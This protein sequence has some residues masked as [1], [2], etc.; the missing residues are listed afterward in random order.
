M[1]FIFKVYLNLYFYFFVS[2]IH[3]LYL[4]HP[5]IF[6]STHQFYLIKN[7]IV[8]LYFNSTFV[9]YILYLIVVVVVVALYCH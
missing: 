7:V 9:Y 2:T 6:L 4:V 5:Y 3:I 8:I 1:F